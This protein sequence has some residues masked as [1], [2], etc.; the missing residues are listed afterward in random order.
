M[1]YLV[2]ETMHLTINADVTVTAFHD[3]LGVECK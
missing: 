3:N 2:H 1:S